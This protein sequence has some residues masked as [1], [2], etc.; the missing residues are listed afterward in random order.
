MLYA[1]QTFITENTMPPDELAVVLEQRGFESLWLPEHTHIPVERRS[2]WPGGADLPAGYWQMYDPFVALA[3]A[4]AVTKSL[5][6]GTGVCLVI[7]HDPIVLAKTV[8]TLD[9]VSGG[10]FIFGIGGGWNAEEME[11]H[12]TDFKTRW[13]LLREQILAMK[14]IWTEDESEFHGRYV[15]FDPIRAYPKPVQ[16][17]HP[18][19]HM[20]GDGA[21][22]F[23]RVV[24]YADG[25]MP[26]GGRREGQTLAE[27]IVSLRRRF[28]AAGRDPDSLQIS[29]FD[30]RP[31]REVID[32]LDAAGVQRVIF[33][34]PVA[35]R[36]VVM[37]LIDQMAKLIH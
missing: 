32:R 34:L 24:E 5:M 26:I 27:K 9:R 4:A 33:G 8:A 6:L 29:S 28:E 18:P 21:T 36:D 19:I 31:D 14:A 13:H 10:R 3:A 35:G 12:G 22:T 37:P 1:I 17:P 16:K 7:E 11:N 15:N 2:P 20:G 30:A 23:D 25:W